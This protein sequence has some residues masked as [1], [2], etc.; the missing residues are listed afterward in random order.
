MMDVPIDRFVTHL[1]AVAT[2]IQH[3]QADMNATRLPPQSIAQ[4]KTLMREV[5]AL[6]TAESEVREHLLEV[7]H[8][9]AQERERYY[10]LFNADP[11]PHIVTN[12]QGVIQEANHA[13]TRLLN[14]TAPLLRDK[15][16]ATYV[17]AEERRDFRAFVLSLTKGDPA[18]R[19]E[20]E[21]RIQGRDPLRLIP[22]V[23]RVVPI[24]DA[25]LQV[26]GLRWLLRDAGRGRQLPSANLLLRSL[27]DASP[28]AIMAVDDE[29]QVQ[30]WNPAAAHLLGWQE[31]EVLV[32]S[33]PPLLLKALSVARDALTTGEYAPDQDG[34]ET[35]FRHK[36]GTPLPVRLILASLPTGMLLLIADLR[37]DYQYR[38]E[39]RAI[40]ARLTAA[41]E[42][43]RQRVAQALHDEVIQQLVA[44]QFQT[45]NLRNL[46]KDPTPPHLT[47]IQTGLSQMG[48]DMGTMVRL[49]RGVIHDMRPPGLAA[50]GLKEALDTLIAQSRHT[51]QVPAPKIELRVPDDAIDLPMPVATVL[52]RTVQEATRNIRHHANALIVIVLLTMTEAEVSVMVQDNG[53]GF[54]CPSRLSDFAHQGHF[55][56]LG[57]SEQIESVGGALQLTSQP[58]K[59]TRLRVTIPLRENQEALHVLL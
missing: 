34:I 8:H 40:K 44:L 57:L 54:D 19:C 47:D 3:I 12:L 53:K 10:D 5:E 51:W 6:H 28:L 1:Q 24:R 4:F 56:L 2:Q 37:S 27:I 9:A 39:V 55:G 26:T 36:D 25:T 21:F 35:E 41:R 23:A 33:A 20:R 16:L 31:A 32:Q 48:S 7:Q 50:F 42:L 30:L 52:L 49:V 43:D 13:A 18:S 17:V 38:A 29:M 58:G 46:T 14:I 11:A 45:V 59:G 15:P 22:V